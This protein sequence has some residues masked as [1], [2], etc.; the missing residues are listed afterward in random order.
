MR[1]ILFRGKRLDTGEWIEGDLLRINGHVFIF[2]D[3]AP[4]GI[5]KYKVDP[6]TVGQYTGL[7]DKNG[8]SFWEGDIFKEDDSG[9]VRSIFRVPGGLAFEDNPVAFGYD[10]RA[11]V[12]PY[13]SIAEMQNASW[14]SQCCEIIGNIHDNVTL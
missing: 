6:A 13:S 8:K 1:E 7:K 5:D 4:K 9:I 11:P 12:Y 3:P 2:P 10:H 14:L